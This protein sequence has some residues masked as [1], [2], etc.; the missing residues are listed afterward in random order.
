M[1][2]YKLARPD[3]WDFHTGKKVNYRENIGKTVH[4]TGMGIGLCT[5]DRIVK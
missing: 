1:K 5:L 4:A 2:Y 3:G